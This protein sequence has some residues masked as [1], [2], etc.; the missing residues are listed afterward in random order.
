VR[1]VKHR[2]SSVSWYG[3]ILSIFVLSLPYLLAGEIGY[4]LGFLSHDHAHLLAKALMVRAAGRLEWLGFVYPPLP[5][6]A[7]IPFPTVHV[8]ILLTAV[9]GG[10]IA[11]MVWL[12]L[13][14]LR[15]DLWAR[16]GIL[17]GVMAACSSIYLASQNLSAVLALVLFLLAWPKFLAFTRF[18]QAD[19]GF[20]AAI[21]MGVAFFASF[22]APLFALGFTL[23]AP[24]FARLRSPQQGLAFILTLIFPTLGVIGAWMYLAWLFTGNPSSFLYDPGSSLLALFRPDEAFLS[25]R[26]MVSEL[27]KRLLQAPLYLGVGVLVAW[28]QPG[29]V[30]VYLLPTM[31]M[32]AAWA[33]GW[34][35]P[36]AF[37]I[38]LLTLFALI[39][40]PPEF[41]RRFQWLLLLGAVLQMVLSWLGTPIGEEALWKKAM[42][43]GTLPEVMVEE[44]VI[45]QY[46]ARLP[47]GSVLA[48]DREAYRLIARAGTACP[49]VLPA[50][51]KYGL[52]LGQPARFV[53]YILISE[54]RNEWLGSLSQRFIRGPALGFET[55]MR[56]KAWRLDALKPS[57]ISWGENP[58]AQNKPLN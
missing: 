9:C 22:Y 17:L 19:A 24:F 6:L 7:L 34:V 28:K 4:S 8:A 14:R 39:G 23:L 5:V 12:Q 31:V 10:I 52:A 21:I 32:V 44:P 47:C 18:H 53:Q 58:A 48:D 2:D 36:L 11:W 25:G 20:I 38:A 46:L 26:A 37:S 56:W 42:F 30:L 57:V 45:G 50:Y 29:R 55:V 41:P 35:F 40:L 51:P 27:F 16:V 1:N 43:N 54:N 13:G 49:F 3:T 15:L 33:M